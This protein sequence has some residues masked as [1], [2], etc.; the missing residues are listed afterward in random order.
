MVIIAQPTD[1]GDP[2]RGEVSGD[3][4]TFAGED[5]DSTKSV[6]CPRPGL[7]TF[8]KSR[9]DGGIFRPRGKKELPALL[10]HQRRFPCALFIA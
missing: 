1:C 2:A 6:D 4:M 9:P 10:S 8:I 5:D 3:Q 7:Y